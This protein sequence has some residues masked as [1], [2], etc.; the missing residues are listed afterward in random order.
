MKYKVRSLFFVHLDGDV[1]APGAVIDLTDD[2]ASLVAHQVELA[3]P[4]AVKKS[5][6]AEA[7]AAKAVADA[8]G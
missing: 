4:A 8:A 1:H 5:V 2:Q 6:A 7:K 3:E